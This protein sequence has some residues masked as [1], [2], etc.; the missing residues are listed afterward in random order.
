[1]IRRDWRFS[2]DGD[3]EMGSPSTNDEGELLYIDMMGGISTDATTG[4]LMRDIP[5]H[6]TENAM[7]QVIMN[8]LRT[9]S[10]DW[11]LHP[12]MGGNLS[13]LVGEPNTRETGQKGS[14]YIVAALTYDNYLAP[15]QIN[16]RPV[17][18]DANTILYYIEVQNGDTTEVTLPVLFNLEHG[19]LSEYEVKK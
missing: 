2:A 14:D 1:M 19:I 16:V 15:S 7:R 12:K 17:P 18:I 5:L 10:P 11:I 6:V 13:D 3:L 9:D 8:R 4:V